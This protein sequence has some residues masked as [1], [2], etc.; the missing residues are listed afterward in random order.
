LIAL[1]EQSRFKNVTQTISTQTYILGA[2]ET[3][4]QFV[5][6]VPLMFGQGMYLRQYLARLVP[7]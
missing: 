1:E 5:S 7:E 3:H 2:K 6:A 4:S